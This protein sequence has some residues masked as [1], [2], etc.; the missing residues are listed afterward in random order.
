MKPRAFSWETE[1]APLM[2]EDMKP[3]DKMTLRWCRRILM[4]TLITGMLL[5]MITLAWNKYAALMNA[6]D[7]DIPT[8]VAMV[9]ECSAMVW[10]MKQDGHGYSV[11]YHENINPLSLFLD[12]NCRVN[13]TFPYVEMSGNSCCR[14]V[15]WNT[16]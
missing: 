3:F 9:N 14:L 10:N 11:I 2:D 8:V 4:L 6:E 7:T 13:M 15:I 12:T 5:T 1:A 16:I